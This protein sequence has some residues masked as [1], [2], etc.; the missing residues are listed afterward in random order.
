MTEVSCE[1]T[2]SLQSNF[3]MLD[4]ERCSMPDAIVAFGQK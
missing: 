4:S 2:V 3:P 1:Q